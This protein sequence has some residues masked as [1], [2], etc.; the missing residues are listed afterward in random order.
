MNGHGLHGWDGVRLKQDKQYNW[1]NPGFPQKDDDPVTLVT[2]GDANAFTAWASRKTG[3]RVRLPTEAE[4]EYAAR[5][6][7]TTP[8]YA[9]KTEEEAAATVGW[10]REHRQWWE[11]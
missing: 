7:T 3:R 1:R 5:G 11:R 2:F 4:F 9:A 6:G 8:W 10:Y